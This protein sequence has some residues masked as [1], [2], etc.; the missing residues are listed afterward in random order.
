MDVSWPLLTDTKV[1][2]DTSEIY[3]CSSYGTTLALQTIPLSQLA[4]YG[5]GKKPSR[6]K[7]GRLNTP[8]LEDMIINRPPTGALKDIQGVFDKP[9]TSYQSKSPQ[10]PK[11]PAVG[12]I[13]KK[14]FISQLEIPPPK[15][16]KAQIPN[17]SII[18]TSDIIDS[19]FG[20][21]LNPLDFV[22]N[23]LKN[24]KPLSESKLLE[25]IQ[26]EHKNICRIAISRFDNYKA[27]RKLWMKGERYEAI[28]ALSELKDD[29]TTVTLLKH[30]FKSHNNRYFTLDMCKHLLPLI[31]GL[32]LERIHYYHEI[33]LNATHLLYR[34]FSQF[35]KQSLSAPL[36]SLGVDLSAEDRIQKCKYCREY[37]IQILKIIKTKNF[38]AREDELGEIARNISVEL[39]TFL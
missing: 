1:N 18:H 16:R 26:L 7:I 20:I 27:I 31:C 39:D 34:S 32:L 2:A 29:A 17:D 6:P 35:I 30:L 28:R 4:P 38:E 9:S 24:A 21:Q 15:S 36:S 33:A 13:P 3:S 10:L 23:S 19:Q 12:S 11:T 14:P 25:T 37:F 8:S 5:D 22:P